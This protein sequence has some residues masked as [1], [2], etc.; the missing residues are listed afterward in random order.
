MTIYHQFE[1]D[2]TLKT[3]RFK[4]LQTSPAYFM[5]LWQV[6][7]QGAG[8]NGGANIDEWRHHDLSM[9][10][11][12]AARVVIEASVGRKEVRD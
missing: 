6:N 8:V 9:G 2:K 3:V 5:Q 12:L 11:D 10:S 7:G 1:A 4:R